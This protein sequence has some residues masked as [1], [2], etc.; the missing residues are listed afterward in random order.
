MLSFLKN[1]VHG[2]PESPLP[3]ITQPGA[4]LKMNRSWLMKDTSPRRITAP[5]DDQIMEQS[6]SRATPGSI[7]GVGR[8]FAL[9]ANEAHGNHF[10]GS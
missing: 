3:S 4:K 2:C 1:L 10:A 8:I 6:C 5:A 9:Q 7:A